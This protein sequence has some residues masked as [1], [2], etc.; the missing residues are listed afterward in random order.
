MA[1]A[2]KDLPG[3]KPGHL[4]RACIYPPVDA[5]AINRL[6]NDREIRLDLAIDSGAMV[7][8]VHL[9]CDWIPIERTHDGARDLASYES[10]MKTAYTET[11]EHMYGESEM[12]SP[13]PL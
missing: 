12:N 9:T 13:I 7:S 4:R 11:D 10:K 3:A 1:R 8:I 2:A 5:L 6:L